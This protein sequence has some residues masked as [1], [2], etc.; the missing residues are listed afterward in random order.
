MKKFSNITGE[1]VNKKPVLD[2]KVNER[3]LFKLK[4]LKMVESLLSIKT[5]GPVDRYYTEGSIEISGKELL[6][7]AITCMLNDNT[8]K[9]QIKVLENLKLDVGDWES[10]DKKIYQLNENNNID[11]KRKLKISN[12]IDKYDS[13]TLVGFLE[14]K[15][16]KMTDV[17]LIND[18]ISVLNDKK[19]NPTIMN[20]INNIV[21]TRLSEIKK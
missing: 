15:F 14:N 11:Y 16:N 13:D 21:S 10:I 20:K 1:N 3:D 4:V 19:V 18:Y 7:E 9:E 17:K 5:Y 2:N 8:I 6:A 12:I